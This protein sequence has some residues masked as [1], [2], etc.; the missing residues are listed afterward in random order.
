MTSRHSIDDATMLTTRVHSM[1]NDQW[2]S[3]CTAQVVYTQNI[4]I[5]HAYLHS[6]FTNAYTDVAGYSIATHIYI[7]GTFSEKVFLNDSVQ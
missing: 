6:L 7:L 5:D 3:V 2:N 1:T 4:C